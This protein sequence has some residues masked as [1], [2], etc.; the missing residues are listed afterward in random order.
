MLNIRRNICRFGLILISAFHLKT[1]PTL[2][3]CTRSKNLLKPPR[4]TRL[5]RALLKLF[6]QSL[7]EP[8]SQKGLM[9]R[10]LLTLSKKKSFTKTL[11][12]NSQLRAS[13]IGPYLSRGNLNLPNASKI[14][15]KENLLKFIKRVRRLKLN[16]K[17]NKNIPTG[18]VQD[19]QP[20]LRSMAPDHIRAKAKLVQHQ[21]NTN[22][23]RDQLCQL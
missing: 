6:S 22:K 23:S 2:T 10:K 1:P 3:K 18:Q 16:K 11:N 4:R 19:G 20:Q 12:C 9:L 8:Q 15:L 17:V 21:L 14:L 13:S 5:K 7:K